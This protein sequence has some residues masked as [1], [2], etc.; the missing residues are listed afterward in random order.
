V[1]T[2]V[3]NYFDNSHAHKKPRGIL[4]D[5]L[6]K[7]ALLTGLYFAATFVF[8]Q[9]YLHELGVHV[10]LLEIGFTGS[11]LTDPFIIG[12]TFALWAIL[13]RMPNRWYNHI[14]ELANP[15]TWRNPRDL[16][17]RAIAICLA[18]WLI[19]GPGVVELAWEALVI[20]KDSHHTILD[21]LLPSLAYF[22]KPYMLPWCIGLG[23]VLFL[24]GCKYIQ[25]RRSGLDEIQRRNRKLI[26][27]TFQVFVP[28][29]LV[30]SLATFWFVLPAN[31]GAYNARRDIREAQDDGLG[32][33]EQIVLS[34]PT[35]I[36]ANKRIQSATSLENL[37]VFE[38][39]ANFAGVVTP[40]ESVHYLGQYADTELFI[41]VSTTAPM[42]SGNTIDAC[43]LSADVIKSIHLK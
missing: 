40:T 30:Y 3:L 18:I 31:Y 8:Q 35:C 21:F 39:A 5:F 12:Y 36:P 16:R 9:A 11:R 14:A 2:Q 41:V 29:A 1:A 25:V 19:I 37:Y 33:V 10:K 24:A 20:K 17:L 27:V 15:V 28:I 34:S 38:D 4:D 13:T 43:L 23:L 6:A 7:T 26:W 32:K 22:S 42:T